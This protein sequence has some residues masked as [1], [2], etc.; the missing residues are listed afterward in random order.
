VDPQPVVTAWEP[1]L[2][3]ALRVRAKAVFEEQVFRSLL[4][5]LGKEQGLFPSG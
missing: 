4:D 5:D 3:E 1:A 2:G